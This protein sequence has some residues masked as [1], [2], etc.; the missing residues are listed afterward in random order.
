MGGGGGRC[1]ELLGWWKG[2]LVPWFVGGAVVLVVSGRI[3]VVL[4]SCRC[5]S[6]CQLELL[7][8]ES[9]WEVR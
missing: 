5:A 7:S 9:L 8:V 3:L 1:G 4:G 6:R 2:G